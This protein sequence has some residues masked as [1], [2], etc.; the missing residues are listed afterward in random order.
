MNGQ[1]ADSSTSPT[2][3]AP[4]SLDAKTTTPDKTFKSLRF[5]ESTEERYWEANNSGDTE[6]KSSPKDANSD[7]RLA[8]VMKRTVELT[9][10]NNIK[11]T[12]ARF[13]RQ[14]PRFVNEPICQVLPNEHSAS[15]G[16]CLSWSASTD[17]LPTVSTTINGSA[18]MP[19]GSPKAR[20]DKQ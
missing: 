19:T 20:S 4:L 18:D 12:C 14:N 6:A 3:Q 5:S 17:S 15:V 13:L 7:N 10:K 16:E 11:G 9:T 2:H 8:S 1:V